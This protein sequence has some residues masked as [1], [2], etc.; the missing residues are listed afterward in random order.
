[1]LVLRLKLSPLQE[2]PELLTTEQSLQPHPYTLKKYFKKET[3]SFGEG[4]FVFLEPLG[5]FKFL[6]SHA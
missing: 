4:R 5:I 2:Q 3:A 1:M 6:K